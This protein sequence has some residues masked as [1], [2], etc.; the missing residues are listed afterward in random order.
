MEEISFK[1]L[2]QIGQINMPV[3]NLEQALVFYRD[4]LGMRYLFK[5]PKM[6]FYDCAGIRLLLAEPE[7]ETFDHPGS[8]IYFKVAD[9]HSVTNTLGAR[10][11]QIIMMSLLVHEPHLLSL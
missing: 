7:G 5:V 3:R 2:A 6:T 11:V 10:G 1:G 9:I 4:T 8:I